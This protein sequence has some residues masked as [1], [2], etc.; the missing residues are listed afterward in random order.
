MK[1]TQVK[2]KT[3]HCIWVTWILVDFNIF[4]VSCFLFTTKKTEIQQ[5]FQTQRK[6]IKQFFNV[7]FDIKWMFVLNSLCKT[8][9]SSR[10]V[11]R[12]SVS[13]RLKKFFVAW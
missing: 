2:E 1:D 9:K 5:N 6:S 13:V 7:F 10:I 8:A 11:W 4:F 12:Q 3:L